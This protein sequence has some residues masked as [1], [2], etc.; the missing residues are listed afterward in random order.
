MQELLDKRV[1]CVFQDNHQN[2]VV[3]GTLK[4]FDDFTIEILG[5][6]GNDFVVIGKNVLVTLKEDWGN[7]KR[8]P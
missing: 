2:K 6:R 8:L 5:E 1:K 4:S 3:R 7:G